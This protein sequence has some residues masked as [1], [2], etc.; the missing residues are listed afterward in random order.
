MKKIVLLMLF[1][2]FVP[3]G[4]EAS[5][6][7]IYTL[8]VRV[9]GNGSVAIGNST[10]GEERSGNFFF[11]DQITIA[12]VPN[13]GNFFY[14]WSY[15]SG[16]AINDLSATTTFIMPNNNVIVTAI[17]G[18]V[19]QDVDENSF[20][21]IVRAYGGGI[22][23]IGDGGAAEVVVGH[24]AAGQVLNIS[25][26]PARNRSFDVWDNEFGTLEHRFR[27]ETSFIM[28]NRNVVVSAFFVDFADSYRNLQWEDRSPVPTHYTNAP[29]TVFSSAMPFVPPAAP[30][31]TDLG[32]GRMAEVHLNLPGVPAGLHPIRMTELSEW[33]IVPTHIWVIDNRATLQ[34]V[35]LLQT[36]PQNFRLFLTLTDNNGNPITIP[37]TFEVDI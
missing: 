32:F 28:P 11:G 30:P 23:A 27:R 34:F 33:I 31:L 1:L 9:V 37:L 36:P 17:F 24:F 35:N 29:F 3:I 7:G 19:E 14:R 4:V 21:L 13:A 16:E 26:I 8:T 15:S 18:D 2:L 22:V 10:F 12:A 6:A 20:S 5:S 25:A